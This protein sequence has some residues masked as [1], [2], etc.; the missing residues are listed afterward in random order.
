ML[1]AGFVQYLRPHLLERFLY[2]D[3]LNRNRSRQRLA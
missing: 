3:T 1:V 2:L